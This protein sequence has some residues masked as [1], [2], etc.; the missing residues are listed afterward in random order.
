MLFDTV[1]GH[2]VSLTHDQP[3]WEPNL[4]DDRREVVGGPILSRGATPRMNQ[5]IV[6]H[7]SGYAE[8]CLIGGGIDPKWRQ[9]QE[10]IPRDMY[11][12]IRGWS[13]GCDHSGTP[14]RRR[15][16]RAHPGDDG[17]GRFDVSKDPSERRII[18][19]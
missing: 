18:E 8:R 17:F 11:T 9:R 12:V 16:L 2:K 3:N 14:Q 19:P 13:G 10:E 6:R 15:V 1:G 4:A 5:H 7:E